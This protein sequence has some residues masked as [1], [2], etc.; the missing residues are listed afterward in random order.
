MWALIHEERRI[1]NEIG[2]KAVKIRKVHCTYTI[3]VKNILNLS[4]LEISG[5][6]HNKVNI[7]CLHSLRLHLALMF[8]ITNTS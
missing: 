5:Q 3:H 4:L 7:T 1:C 8:F 6:K 2:V